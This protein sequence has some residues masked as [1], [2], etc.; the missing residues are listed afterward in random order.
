MH[1][2]ARYTLAGMSIALA[3]R[4]HGNVT[5]GIEVRLEHLG[6][7]EEFVTEGVQ[8]VQRDTDIRGR[9][10]LLQF[11]A[12]LKIDA[13]GTTLQRGEGNLTVP[14][15]RDITVFAGTQS[16]G[17]ALTLANGSRI[18][19][20]VGVATGGTVELVGNPGSTL[21]GPL[22]NRKGFGSW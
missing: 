14:Q 18:W 2:R 17:L 16:M 5:D 22:V 4:T 7:T 8:S 3:T 12:A 20:G 1:S 13:T 6:I 11:S 9:D 15:R 21:R 19:Q 10:P